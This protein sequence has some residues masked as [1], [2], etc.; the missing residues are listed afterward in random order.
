M[1]NQI[2]TD[3]SV[4]KCFILRKCQIIKRHFCIK[5]IATEYKLVTYFRVFILFPPKV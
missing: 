1:W 5:Y 4:T 2:N 3:I